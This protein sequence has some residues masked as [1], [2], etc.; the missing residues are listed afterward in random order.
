MNTELFIARRLNSTKGTQDNFSKPMIKIAVIGIALGLAVMILSIAIVTGFKSEIRNKVIGFGAHIQIV[1]FD[2]NTSFETNPLNKN[3]DF[4]PAMEEIEGI[5]H[6]QIFATKAG[7]IKAKE[8]IQG[9]VLKG[10][11]SRFDWHF[12]DNYIVAGKSF[13]VNDTIT[14]DSLVISKSIAS[15]LKLDVGDKIAM[16]FIQKPPR[17][18]KFIISGIY[19]TNLE[20]FDKLFVLGDI[21]HVQKLNNWDEDQVSGFEVTIDDFSQLKEMTD[22]VYDQ[23]GY[24]FHE[25]GSKLRVLNIK[26]KYPQ[27]FDWLK[28]LDINV[29][30]ILIL[31]VAVA[32]FNMISALLILILERTNMIGILKA[33]GAGN[34]LIQKVFLYQ[35][36]FII[37]RGLFWGNLIGVVFC[38]LQ[39]YF[40]IITLDP[41]SY[42]ITVVPINLDIM[43]L[44]LLNVGTLIVTILILILPTMIISK[45]NPEKT[46]RFD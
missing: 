1:N 46:I 25:D 17:M 8:E 18:R 23:V 44:L 13:K 21:K 39:Y 19:E 28:L 43:S 3:Q 11:D 20:E 35:S 12:F 31:M 10:V 29:L 7:I 24:N 5:K 16:F 27:L 37:S 15:L 42:Y 34:K 30:I 9:V 33:V 26:E 45:I 22:I 32:G 40:G 6:I 14:N 2:A 4:Y 38:L 36:V 41:A